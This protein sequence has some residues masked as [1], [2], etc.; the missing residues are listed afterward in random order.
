[1]APQKG[2]GGPGGAIPEETE[3][4]AGRA[5]T[6]SVD[7][8]IDRLILRHQRAAGAQLDRE[9]MIDDI[10]ER[11]AF[12]FA[13][14][15]GRSYV[16]ARLRKIIEYKKQLEVLLNLPKL[17]QRTPAWYEA[18]NNLITASDFA[19]C[20]GHGK[21]G[22]PKQ[23]YEKKCG[24]EEDKFDSS[25]PALRWGIMFEDVAAS[26][27]SLKNENVTVHEFGLLKHPR[28]SHLGASPDG[29]SDL[30][31]MIEI[32]CP[33][34]RKITGDIPLQYFYQMQGQLDVCGLDECDYLECGFV[35]YDDRGDFV[36]HFNNTDNFKGIIA[37]VESGEESDNPGKKRYEYVDKALWGDMHKQLAW[38]D[39]LAASAAAAGESV[40]GTTFWQLKTY[41]VR[42]V[43]RD[44]TF[45]GAMYPRLADVWQ[46]VVSFKT[47]KH[48][49][50]FF[51]HGSAGTSK[52][53]L[54]PPKE[55][56][57]IETSAA[58]TGT[59]AVAP[60]G[61]GNSSNSNKQNPFASYAFVEDEE[62]AAPA[63]KA[64][65][66][67]P[68]VKTSPYFQQNKPVAKAT[69]AYA[70]VDEDDG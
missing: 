10:V 4:T 45:I 42:R 24:Y 48:R 70:F 30:G 41:S 5:E 57:S 63:A 11:M 12:V 60:A 52:K 19:Q 36:R 43:Y 22:T 16:S 54:A 3:D 56:M 25:M 40:V 44:D 23:F 29:I 68:A 67:Q 64:Q 32:K 2:G 14:N 59:A 33:W 31:V 1:M 39:A 47:D 26:A 17:D 27:Y 20:L 38:L 61:D 28:V 15:V 9:R 66:H 55:H 18:R 7:A 65:H 69:A 35:N 62:D 46:N 53:A 58:V 13:Q 21:F 6:V 50:D 34:R 8:I 51:M 37:E 49:Y